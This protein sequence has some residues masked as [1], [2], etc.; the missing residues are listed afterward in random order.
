MENYLNCKKID[1]AISRAKKILTK[2]AK[3]NGIYENFGQKEFAE[4]TDK[5][6]DCCDYSTEMNNNRRKM[7]GFN[8][9]IM[10]YSIN[11]ILSS[12]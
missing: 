9:W 11:N 1:T 2:K 8:Y 12:I 10:T 7:Q 4:I 5:F 6:I 3:E